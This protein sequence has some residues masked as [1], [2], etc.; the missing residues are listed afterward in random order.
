MWLRAACS[1]LAGG[2]GGAV[3]PYVLFFQYLELLA[4]CNLCVACPCEACRAVTAA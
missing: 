1:N 3:Q 4:V 2:G